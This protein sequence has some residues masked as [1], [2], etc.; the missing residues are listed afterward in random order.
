MPNENEENH[1]A[2]ESDEN[3]DELPSDLI[4]ESRLNLT[5][6]KNAEELL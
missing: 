1:D 3:L 2:P 6:V 5:A 4:K